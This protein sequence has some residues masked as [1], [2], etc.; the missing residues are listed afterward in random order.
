MNISSLQPT[1]CGQYPTDYSIRLVDQDNHTTSIPLNVTSS[2]M[3]PVTAELKD[4]PADFSYTAVVIVKNMFGSS[5]SEPAS[6][7]ELICGLNSMHTL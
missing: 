3:S 4:L 7:C 2:S 5:Q 6:I 1:Q